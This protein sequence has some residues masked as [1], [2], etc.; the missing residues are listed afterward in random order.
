MATP[1]IETSNGYA[2]IGNSPACSLTLT[3]ANKIIAFI[4]EGRNPPPGTDPS[5]VTWGA[6]GLTKVGTYSSTLW[7]QVWI[8]YLDNPTAGTANLTANFG[9]G[10]QHAIAGAALLNAASGAPAYGGGSGDSTTP[11]A[12]VAGSVAD[13]LLLGVTFTDD[14]AAFSAR[15]GTSIYETT[16][17]QNDSN[18]GAQYATAAGSSGNLNWT[19]VTN[20]WAAMAIAVSASGSGPSTAQRGAAP[21]VKI[22]QPI[23]TGFAR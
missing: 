22:F 7:G 17:I 18:F 2:F 8:Y 15:S 21:E 3:S 14:N 4:G 16:E 19:I 13:D 20:P 12:T 9:D 6:Q 10:I 11:S 5:S 1:T 23:I